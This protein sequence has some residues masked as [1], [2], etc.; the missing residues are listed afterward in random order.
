MTTRLTST[1]WRSKR[2]WLLQLV[3]NALLLFAFWLW[4]SVPEAHVWEV[5]FSFLLAVVIV[6]TE[7][8]LQCATLAHFQKPPDAK[9]R[10]TFGRTWS[11]VPLFGIW[12]AIGAVLFWLALHATSQ[13]GQL[14]GWLR[15]ALPAFLRNHI[16][17][18]HCANTVEAAFGVIAWILVP[19]FWLPAAARISRKASAHSR[20]SRE[21]RPIRRLTWWLAYL[22]LFATG[23]YAPYKLVYWIPEVTG[24]RRQTLS[25]G[26][27]FAAAYVLIITSWWIMAAILGRHANPGGLDDDEAIG[28]REPVLVSPPRRSFGA[29]AESQ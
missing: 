26:I 13:S 19:A 17:P 3:L 20:Q 18:R 8:W 12:I 25:M 4:L 28:V 7:L 21:Q 10:D 9:L 14:G 1:L 22:V 6:W 27:R 16:S 11:R 24:L 5:A 23:G 15:H 2:I 29:T